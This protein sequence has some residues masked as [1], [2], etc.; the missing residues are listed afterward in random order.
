MFIIGKET[1]FY[2]YKTREVLF[3]VECDEIFKRIA[4]SVGFSVEEIV[5]IELDKKNRNARPRSLD[6]YFESAIILKKS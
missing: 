6:K 4:S 2:T 1:I 3:R 5:D